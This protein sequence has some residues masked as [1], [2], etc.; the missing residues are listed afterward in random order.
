MQGRSR[1]RPDR[2]GQTWQHLGVRPLPPSSSAPFVI[3]VPADRRRGAA[4]LLHG[5][6][7][8]PYEV[9]VLGDDF[10]SRLGLAAS[11]PLLPGHGDDPAALNHLQWS[12]WLDAAVQAYDRLD[13]LDPAVSS[14][15]EGPH[16]PRVV[17]G[18]SMGGLLA[19]HVS[20]VRPVDAVVLLAPALRFFELDTL[21]ILALAAGLWRLRPFVA[22]EGPGGDVGADDAARLNPT[23]K[24][25]PARG[26]TELLSLQWHTERLLPA[27]TTPVCILHGDLDRTIAPSSSRII[28]HRVSSAVVEHHRLRRTRHLVG[29]DVE[30][31]LV[32]DLATNFVRRIL[33]R[34][35]VR[36]PPPTLATG[37]SE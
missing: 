26:I 2:R 34:R 20:R 9:R 11:G 4:L 7:G 23:Y 30:R 6:T 37:D 15:T 19:L 27:V 3:D 32:S 17:V 25:M 1:H 18:C 21:S 10:A 36:V 28:A 29:L 5:Y 12:A 8:T 13:A 16:R 33:D 22:K 31:D 14:G 35:A 24:T